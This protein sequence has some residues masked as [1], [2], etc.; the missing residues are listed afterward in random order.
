MHDHM[1]QKLSG[2]ANPMVGELS[3]LLSRVVHCQIL[4]LGDLVLKGAVMAS[5]ISTT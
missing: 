2:F 5:E 3:E 4:V 1:L